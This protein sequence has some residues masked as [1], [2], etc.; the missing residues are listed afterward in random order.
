VYLGAIDD[1]TG[2]FLAGKE[3][4][5]LFQNLF[6]EDTDGVLVLQSLR[7]CK[8]AEALAA[9]PVEKSAASAPAL[10]SENAA[11]S[12]E[13][14]KDSDAALFA[15]VETFKGK[16]TKSFKSNPWSMLVHHN[17]NHYIRDYPGLVQFLCVNR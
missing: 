9:A 4:F 7:E 14:E 12:S 1:K 15:A 17:M 10:S 2:T 11:L 6:F 5:R 3:K 8:P 16:L 13:S